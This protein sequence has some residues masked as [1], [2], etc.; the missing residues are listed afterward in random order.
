MSG[1]VYHGPK[2]EPYYVTDSAFGISRA[3]HQGYPAI[4]LNTRTCRA[5]VWRIWNRKRRIVVVHWAKWWE[6]GFRPKAGKHV[7]RKPIEKLTL[8]QVQNLISVDGKH[9]ILTAEQAARLCQ[10]HDIIPFFEMKPSIWGLR[11][12]RALSAFCGARKI[13]FVLTTI[14]CYGSTARAKNRWEAKAFA[15]MK[16]ARSA[17]T[18]TCLLYRRPLDWAKWSPVL[19]GIKDRPGHGTVLGLHE[20]IHRLEGR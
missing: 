7:P 2:G 16:L 14:Q 20:L 19:T 9:V 6:H 13:P 3:S 8:A 18:K 5:N 4:D 15:R 11:V 1:L 12:L 17:G 10:L